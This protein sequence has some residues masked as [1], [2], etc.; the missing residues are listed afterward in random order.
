MRVLVDTH[1]LLWAITG[2][3]GG[4]P[5]GRILFSHPLPTKCSSPPLPLGKSPRSTVLG[6]FHLLRDWLLT[7]AGSSSNLDFTRR[8]F[9]LSMR[10]GLVVFPASIAI[11]LTGC[12]LPRRRA[13]TCLW[14][15]TSES[16]T[17]TTSRESGESGQ[18]RTPEDSCSAPSKLIHHG[19][20]EAAEFWF[21]RSLLGDLRASVV[22]FHTYR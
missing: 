14:S 13:R 22:N 15:A 6:S 8:R 7:L 21:L 4:F 10:R 11:H 17:S 2:D 3:P 20:T 18:N 5:R 9:R 16:S 1:A 12:W 19:D